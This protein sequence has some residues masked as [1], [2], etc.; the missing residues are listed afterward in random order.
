[1][2]LSK[3]E[4]LLDNDTKN[5]VI[6]FPETDAE[7]VKYSMAFMN[8]MINIKWPSDKDPFILTDNFNNLDELKYLWTAF[9]VFSMH[10]PHQS[11]SSKAI[12]VNSGQW[13]PKEELRGF[14]QWNNPFTSDSFYETTFKHHL[15]ED[16][17]ILKKHPE[18]YVGIS[19][20]VYKSSTAQQ[21][22]KMKQ[23][24]LQIEERFQLMLE[25]PQQTAMR[26]LEESKKR[27]E[28]SKKE[29]I[30]R[31]EKIRQQEETQRNVAMKYPKLRLSKK[32]TVKFDIDNGSENEIV[33]FPKTDKERV[34]FSMGYANF[35]IN[36][37]KPTPSEPYLIM[38]GTKIIEAKY[39][40]T[41]CMVF[42]WQDS[43][44]SWDHK[45]LTLR[46]DWDPSKEYTTS[47]L[48]GYS[49]TYE[50]L[51]EKVFKHH[52]TPD[53]LILKKYPKLY[54]DISGTIC[55]TIET[56]QQ[57]KTEQ[58]SGR[59][60]G[61]TIE[62]IE[63]RIVKELNE[64]EE[65]IKQGKARK[66]E[67]ARKREEAQKKEKVI[68]AKKQ[69]ETRKREEA[70][71]KEKDKIRWEE[72]KKK[73]DQEIFHGN[74]RSAL[75][76]SLENFTTKDLDGH[77]EKGCSLDYKYD[78]GNTPLHYAIIFGKENI[79]EYMLRLGANPFIKNK[80]GKL[81][82]DLVSSNSP[83]YTLLKEKEKNAFLDKLPLKEKYSILLIEHVSS[84]EAQIQK[85]NEYL[86]QGA[87]INYQ[88]K[89]GFTPLMAAIDAQNER[90]AEYLIKKGA[91]TAI[92]NSNNESASDLISPNSSLFSVLQDTKKKAVIEK[93]PIEHHSHLLLE[94]VKGFDVKISKIDEYLSLG[95]DI[96]YQDSIGFSAL[97]YAV[98]SQNDR[99]A[100][101][102]LNSGANPFL[103]NKQNKT[104]R[105]L[106]SRN[107][108]LHQ[109][110]KGYELLRLVMDDNLP[111]V[112]FLL[113]NDNSIIDF[114]GHKGYSALFIAV[115]LN[116]RTMAEY[117]LLQNPNLTLICE[118]GS[119]VF[120]IV[121]DE[122]IEKLLVQASYSHNN[123][124][125]FIEPDEYS[126]N[127]LGFF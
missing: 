94:H 88:N 95:A 60:S 124:E 99:I 91:N 78:D 16:M 119:T 61:E 30:R 74:L 108:S 38:C 70:E 97:M 57:I 45:S 106:A 15:T 48:L 54:E 111:K 114:Q 122:V 85:I 75:R 18:L 92:L 58:L 116:L 109:F 23:K 47:L 26:K 44:Q 12:Y 25:T 118:E 104:A 102:L 81:P 71:K 63:I 35:L 67:E 62:Q 83:L 34:I 55:K 8:F 2:S 123:N 36:I 40:W 39:I 86:S 100:E 33:W 98:D 69:E 6:Y 32:T 120:E 87:D 89:N 103:T 46:G 112:K 117:L 113:K 20:D 49:Y 14:W 82:I 76:N 96:N 66:Q 56:Q 126:K 105:A 28:A 13:M 73:T 29:E 80:K 121:N 53:M 115:E 79:A 5:E 3:I 84:H 125:Q 59:K 50:S 77:I 51:Y 43:K 19:S 22:V 11:F 10:D 101:Y 93:N 31:E 42:G 4:N 1:M 110:I 41:A 68:T 9:M 65:L 90:I 24:G 27:E 37:R 17:L 7:R 21:I 64:Q 127:N 52:L 107:S 72:L